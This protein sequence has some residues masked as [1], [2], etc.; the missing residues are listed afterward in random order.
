M[1]R[2]L[3]GGAAVGGRLMA[4]ARNGGVEDGGIIGIYHRLHRKDVRVPAERFHGAEDHGLAADLAILLGP[5]SAGAEPAPGCDEDGC[6]A[7]GSRHLN[8]NTDVVGFG[9]RGGLPGGAQPYHAE[10]GMTERFTM[11]VGKAVFVAVHL[12][13]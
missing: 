5:A 4:Q 13:K 2:S 8:S 3:P 6:C 11:V 1:H 9:R 12:H 10:Y 7:L